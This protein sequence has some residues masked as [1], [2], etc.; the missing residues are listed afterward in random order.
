MK[1]EPPKTEK[2]AKLAEKINTSTHYL[3]MLE[4]QRKFPSPEMMERIAFA[5]GI[6]TTELF[7]K[8]T[9]P[10]DVIRAYRIAA[11]ED[12]Q[13]AVGKVFNER[14]S[15]LGAETTKK[16]RQLDEEN[17]EGSPKKKED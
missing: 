15:E 6:D 11:I 10:D 2:Q 9:V 16:A 12:I 13:W 1:N 7:L 5:L 17:E 14:F 8:E 3:G 4:L